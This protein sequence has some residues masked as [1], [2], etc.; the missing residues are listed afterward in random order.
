MS[1]NKITQ[2]RYEMVYIKKNNVVIVHREPYTISILTKEQAEEFGYDISKMKEYENISINGMPED[3][4]ELVEYYDNY[5]EPDITRGKVD[6][7]DPELDKI[8]DNLMNS[9]K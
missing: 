4:Y 6:Y 1:S 3:G 5:Q 9:H 2:D 7:V 8:I